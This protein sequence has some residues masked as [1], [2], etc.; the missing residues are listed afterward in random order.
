MTIKYAVV[1]LYFVD[2]PF[3]KFNVIKV[4]ENVVE[5]EAYRSD[6]LGKYVHPHP[7]NFKVISYVCD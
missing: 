1:D 4:F 3:P 2:D 6:W 7:S 5:A